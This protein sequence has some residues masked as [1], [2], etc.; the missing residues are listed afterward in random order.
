MSRQRGPRPERAAGR[1]LAGCPDRRPGPGPGCPAPDCVCSARQFYCCEQEYHSMQRREA[2]WRA[3]Q[4]APQPAEREW[5]AP[6][7]NSPR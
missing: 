6:Q 7:P 1:E 4:H 2:R 5:R 3:A